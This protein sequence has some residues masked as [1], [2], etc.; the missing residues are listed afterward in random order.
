MSGLC[1]HL[2]QLAVPAWAIGV[3]DPRMALKSKQR[4]SEMLSNFLARGRTF[5]VTFTLIVFLATVATACVGQDQTITLADSGETQANKVVETMKADNSTGTSTLTQDLPAMKTYNR[6]V[7]VIPNPGV[8]VD[9]D[10][11]RK[12]VLEKYNLK[13]GEAKQVCVVP[14]QVPAG[15]FYEYELE[16]SEVWREGVFYIGS[17]DDKPEGTWRF[18][19]SMNCQVVGQRVVK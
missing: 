16:W 6:Q 19:Q 18:L 7:K 15:K 1:T 13:D 2:V 10:A 9:T 4:R 11:V 17:P 12:M 3:F 14:V 5:G 8:K